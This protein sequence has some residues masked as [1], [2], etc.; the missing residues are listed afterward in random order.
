MAPTHPSQPP[1]LSVHRPIILLA[2]RLPQPDR[3]E[4]HPGQLQLLDRPP[5]LSYPLADILQRNESNSP[6]PRAH[7]LEFFRDEVVPCL[8]QRDSVVRLPDPANAQTISW[9]KDRRRN[10]SLI[11]RIEP[12]LRVSRPG[13]QRAAEGAVPIVPGV[14]YRAS[15]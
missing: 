2:Q 4:H 12:A 3:R 15:I 13:A 10:T 8:A 5:Q 9:E 11:H 6:E 7:L 14:K 1:A